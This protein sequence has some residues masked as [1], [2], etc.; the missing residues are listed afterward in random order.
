MTSS[1]ARVTSLPMGRRFRILLVSAFVVSV[2]TDALGEPAEISAARRD[3][4]A[5][6]ASRPADVPEGALV[7]IEYYLDVARRNWSKGGQT[8]NARRYFRQAVKM[9]GVAKAG[10]DPFAKRRGFVVRAYRSKISTELQGYSIYVP[11]SYDSAK[12][13]PLMATLHG[14][15][16]NHSLFLGVFFNNNTPWADYSANL[17][18]Q[19]V[20][21]WQTD[22]LV[23]APNG[24]G[25]VLW[26]W[27]G[28]QDVLDVLDDVALHYRVDPNRVVLNGVSNGGMGTYS[29]GARYAW[30][31]VA[32]LPMAG[33]PSWRQYLHGAGS[34]LDDRLISAFGAWDSADNLRNTGLFRFFHGD[35]DTGPMKCPFVRRFRDRLKTLG[36]PH[37]YTEYSM[38]HDIMYRVHRRG[39]LLE[40]ISALRRNPRPEK[41]WVVAW[42]YR[43]RRQHWL[44]VEHFMDFH[45]SARLVGEVVEEG[46]RLT[47]ETVNTDEL[48]V[49]LGDCPIAAEGE[50]EVLVDGQLVMSLGNQRPT[51]L[52]LSRRGLRW[53]EGA[54]PHVDGPRKRPG[55]S[56][57]LT[58]V[59]H[60]CQVHAYGTQVEPDI[61]TLRKAA[62]RAA[63]GGWASW[64]WNYRHPVVA[65]TAVTEEMM[66][67]CSLVLYGD[68]GSNS[69][70]AKVA[71]RLPIGLELGAIVLGDRRF[72]SKKVGT[73]FVVPNPLAPEQYLVI[74]AGNSAAA[75]AAGSKLPDFLPDWVVYDENSTR[76]RP[77][78]VF[79]R[80][81]QPLDAG[82]FTD[83][84]QLPGEV[85]PTSSPR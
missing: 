84:W 53:V 62:R 47:I 65:D 51:E 64:A 21:R 76:R 69:L 23:V 11:E 32:V 77:R 24:F 61:A 19:Y 63:T 48:T 54:R 66:Q 73:R 72:T 10:S 59:L 79:A 40:E 26:R 3:L 37:T 38:G 39:K 55:L 74:Q 4:T 7:S 20:P 82:F 2:A 13:T 44:R 35:A 34:P 16:S 56:G 22:W 42:D 17:L 58:D 78:G 14:G 68:V 41:V 25:Q 9:I 15:S 27:E 85:S 45:E 36:V 31:F 83:S 18:K 8:D 81:K 70:L 67:R 60:T 52:L 33:A 29:L 43:A 50:V 1:G 6:Q 28:E 5:L 30:R 46:E 80:G 49:F 57:P 12:A 75:V 71:P